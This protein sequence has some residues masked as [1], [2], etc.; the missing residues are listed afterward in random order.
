MGL[1]SCLYTQIRCHLTPW[2]SPIW[3]LLTGNH[4]CLCH[5]YRRSWCI[6]VHS[7]LLL[8]LSKQSILF[9][10]T[11]HL[12]FNVLM[13]LTEVP[14][15]FLRLQGLQRERALASAPIGGDHFRAPSQGLS[16]QQ[17]AMSSLS[18]IRKRICTDLCRGPETSAWVSS[19]PEIQ[20]LF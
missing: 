19:G 16:W 10:I 7:F 3:W 8:H 18:G 11:Y 4:A 2:D 20:L 14:F 12:S 6:A 15:F 1:R 9:I 17:P 5:F 13:E